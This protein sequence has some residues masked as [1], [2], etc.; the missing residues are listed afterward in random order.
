MPVPSLSSSVIAVAA[1]AIAAA[2]AVGAVGFAQADAPLPPA[3]PD[4]SAPSF[5]MASAAPLS[6][7]IAVARRGGMLVLEPVVHA[8]DRVEGT[9]G[10]RV[11]GGGGGNRS[12]IGQGGAF[13]AR[14]NV[15]VSLGAVSLGSGTYRATMEVQA[16]RR[17]ATCAVTASR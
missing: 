14:A 13:E 17:S 15:P 6:C 4:L 1:L 2:G 16:G 8:S 3:R 12:D 5:Q 10:L 11:S 9:W 7:E